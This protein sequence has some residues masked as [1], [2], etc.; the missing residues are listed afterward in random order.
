MRLL[1]KITT[2]FLGLAIAVALMVSNTGCTAKM[3]KAYHE[4]RAEKFY[5]AGQYD[6]AEIEYKNVLR[7]VP[8]DGQAIGRLG[9]IYF[10]QGRLQNAAPYLHKGSELATNDLDL[11]L[12]LG[13]IYAAMGKMN[14]AHAA[15][16]YVLDRQPQNAEAPLLL[17]Q[18][19]NS[20]KEIATARARLQKLAASGDRAAFEVALGTLSVNENDIKNAKTSYQRALALDPR[21]SQAYA[22]LGALYLM[23]NDLTNAEA[24]LKAAADF[25]P[26]RSAVKIVY[27]RFKVAT[28]DPV[29]GRQILNDMVSRTPDYMPALMGL[30]GIAFSEK[31]YDESRGFVNKMLARDADNFDAMMLDGQLKLAQNDVLAATG[32]LERMVRLYPQ[33]PTAHYQLAQAYLAGNDTTKAALSLGHALDISPNFADATLL[34]AQI[35]I[36]SQNPD[37]AIFALEKL[38]QKQP[39]LVQAQLLLADAYRQRDRVADAMAIYASLEKAFP[40]NAQIPL[41]AG[42]AYVQQN[43]STSARREFNR[44]LE[45]APD[46]LVAFEQLIDL[47]L[48]EKK[49]ENAMQLIQGRLQTSPDKIELY[50]LEAKTFLAEK[51]RG[52]ATAALQKAIQINPDYLGVYLLLA[53]VYTD[54]GQ[55]DKALAQ[56]DLALAKDPKNISA[57]MAKAAIYGTVKD[58]KKQADTYES[59]LVIDPKFSPALNNLAYLYSQNIIHLDRAYDLA[60]RARALLPFDPNAA[61]T[62]GWICFLRGS[63]PAALG[64]LQESAAKLSAEPE[65]QYHLGMANYIVGNE[66]AAHAAFQ[67]ALQLNPASSESAESKTCLAILDVN[68]QTADAGTIALLEKRIAEKSGDPVA[69]GRLAAA[70]QHIGNSDKAIATYEAVLK[71]DADNLSA[72][73]NL[74]QLYAQKDAVKAYS[75]ARS[76]YKLASDNP[77]AAHIY[78]RLAYQNGDFKLANTLLQQT[79]QNQTGDSQSFFDLGQ[80]AY[81]LGKISDAQDAL[82]NAL[83]LNLPAPQSAEAK[84]ILDLINL[85]ADSAQAVAATARISE[86]LKAQPNYVPALMVAGVID[87]RNANASAATTAYE[88]ILARFPDFSPAQRQL[89]ILYSRDP[90]KLAQASDLIAKAR[91]VYPDDPALTKANGIVVF[92]QGDFSRAASQLKNAAAVFPNDAELFYYLGAAQF[93]LKNNADSKASLQN[94]LALKLSGPQAD[95]AKQMLA[96]LK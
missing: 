19:L 50:V 78:G 15:A 92:Q 63:Y 91:A 45:A 93:K 17:I 66:A 51:E 12:K 35:Q 71:V 60:Q 16:G 29:A 34:L 69:L 27:A 55:N 46:N 65:I 62:L 6:Q 5:A 68:P 58:Y 38:I 80:S 74:A 64:L 14:E 87:E 82:N 53:Q 72:M 57:L 47:D 44:A 76:A 1:K 31:K 37:P 43:D 67:R 9:L 24:N 30:A 7:S 8:G 42:A 49:F 59:V 18:G 25:A 94:A 36:R 20:Q 54:A 21:F 26:D 89:A 88:K 75:I 13:F 23:Q 28:G 3:K 2:C 39:Q 85:A 81:S 4:K 11:R 56:F 77:V 22:A 86:I 40:K 41:L 33:I 84:Q 70:Y 96:Q 83:Q 73:L 95:A 10:Q 61:D 90:A 32:E 79:V 52:Q 48:N